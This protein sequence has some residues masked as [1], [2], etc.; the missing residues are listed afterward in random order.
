MVAS[1]P[2]LYSSA[3]GSL[4]AARVSLYDRNHIRSF[5]CLTTPPPLA[6]HIGNKIQTLPP[7]MRLSCFL[8]PLLPLQSQLSWFCLLL[9]LSSCTGL[10]ALVNTPSLFQLQIFSFLYPLCGNLSLKPYPISLDSQSTSFR[11]LLTCYL[12][13]E[14]FL[15]YHITESPFQSRLPTL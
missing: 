5:P 4:H 13:S 2:P 10:L 12:I 7:P 11:V 1:L 9:G 3:V 8:W 15:D 14:D 6:Y